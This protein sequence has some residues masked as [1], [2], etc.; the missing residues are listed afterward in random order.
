MT[1]EDTYNCLKSSKIYNSEHGGYYMLN[2]IYV[3]YYKDTG[4]PVYKYGYISVHG[5]IFD[6]IKD[7]I[8]SD[9][10]LTKW[11]DIRFIDDSN[12]TTFYSLVRECER[13]ATNILKYT[14]PDI[15][16]K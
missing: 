14:E 15:N 4:M 2:N 16:W 5:K 7:K 6:I 10:L 13:H 9:Q 1:E 8:I 11:I 12:D 3:A